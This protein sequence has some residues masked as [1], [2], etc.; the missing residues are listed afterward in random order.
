MLLGGC[1]TYAETSVSELSP[2]LQ[3]RVR[4]DEDGFGRVVNQAA[5]R[6]VP[7]TM[8]D[9]SGR[10]VVGRVVSLGASNMT[11]GHDVVFAADVPMRAMQNVAVRTFGRRRTSD[12]GAAEAVFFT[13]I[14]GGTAGPEQPTEAEQLVVPV[15]PLISRSS[16]PEVSDFIRAVR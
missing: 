6:G 2:G 14:Y 12:V 13:A 11:V 5:E 3:A 10:G 7:V 4:L 8:V 15:S 9:M 16:S 1:Y